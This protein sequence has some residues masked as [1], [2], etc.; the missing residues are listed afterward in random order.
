MFASASEC[1]SF[2]LSE[3]GV[4]HQCE[5]CDLLFNNNYFLELLKIMIGIY[6][7]KYSRDPLA[8]MR[9]QDLIDRPLLGCQFR[10]QFKLLQLSYMR[11]EG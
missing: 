1:L 6:S 8:M 2:H 7:R 5:N 9:Y 3:K 11:L 10:D 4:V